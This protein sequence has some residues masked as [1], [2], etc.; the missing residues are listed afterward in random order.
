[1]SETTS[2]QIT[3][4]ETITFGH[5][6]VYGTKRPEGT[7]V[8]I[9]GESFLDVKGTLHTVCGYCGDPVPGVKAYHAN[10]FEGVCFQCNGHGVRK[11]V[12]SVEEATK[13]ARRRIR[14]RERAAAKR[15]AE[16]EAILA[17][18]N[19]WAERHPDL[20]K[21]L[22]AIA[23]ETEG[24]DGTYDASAQNLAYERYGAFVVD[25]AMT[26]RHR[27]LTPAQQ[28]A[29]AG[30]I[31]AADARIAEKEAERAKARYIGEEGAKV[32][33]R[34]TVSVKT[35]VDDFYARYEGATKP[36]VIVTGVG[37]FEGVTV[38]MIGTAKALYEVERG[39]EVEVTG[40]VKGHGEYQ[41]V[42]QTTV[43]RPKIK[44]LHQAEEA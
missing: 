19:E 35:F 23:A 17:E 22:T 13:V 33:V 7:W 24:S 5:N 10:V 1:M 6:S 16:F 44:V 21:R 37:E 39:D 8:T 30:A 11:A 42:L 15:T 14:S 20:A 43:T 4:G 32:T 38:K 29:V 26:S 40:T 2:P 3:R 25:L 31:E 41:G 12:G 18:R 34:G 28:T 9:D 27:R 36:L